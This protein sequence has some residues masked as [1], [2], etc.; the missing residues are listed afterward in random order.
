MIQKLQ[1]STTC[2]GV[3]DHQAF[4]WLG[5]H[6]QGVSK[7]GSE[8]HLKHV[9]FNNIVGYDGV[10]ERM[11][12]ITIMI[13]WHRLKKHRFRTAVLYCTEMYVFYAMR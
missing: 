8:D 11:M 6:F 1:T 12:Y 5:L 4:L 3:R 13:N 2:E 7:Y 10:L 9:I